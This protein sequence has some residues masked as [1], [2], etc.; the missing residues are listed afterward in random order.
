MNFS[1]LHGQEL[2]HFLS[3]Y[4]K[5]FEEVFFALWKAFILWFVE[6]KQIIL[7]FKRTFLVLYAKLESVLFPDIYFLWPSL[8][9]HNYNFSW[10]CFSRTVQQSSY[11]DGMRDQ[12]ICYCQCS[13]SLS[14][15]SFSSSSLE[16]WSAENKKY[17]SRISGVHA[18]AI[19]MTFFVNLVYK[20]NFT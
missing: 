2:A 4:V 6:L 12:W 7:W 1:T 17:T 16:R 20:F 10:I 13:Q 8:E 11:A 14:S 15:V 5:Y 18:G 9:S 3:E 19:W